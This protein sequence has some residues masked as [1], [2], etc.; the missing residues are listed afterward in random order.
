M[1]ALILAGGKGERLSALTK[2]LI[3]KPMAEICGKPILQRAVERLRENG[4]TELFMSVSHLR[5]VIENHFGDG[6]KFGVHIRYIVERQ[7]LGSGG[8]L[9]YLKDV[10]DD[11]FLVCPG[12]AIFDVDFSRMLAFHRE[13]NSLITMFAHPNSHPYDSD[14]IVSRDSGQVAEINYKNS[15]RNFYYKNTVSSG[16]LI[17][18]PKTLSFFDAP[19]TVNMEK[20]FVSHFVPQGVVYAYHSSEYVKDVGT[21]ER[22]ALAEKDLKSNLV[23][24]KNLARKQKAVFLDRDG[25]LN[26]YKGFIANVSDIELVDG[27]AEAIKKINRSEYLAIVVS[28]QAV[29]ARGEATF[30]DVNQMFAKIETLLGSGGAYLDGIFYCPHHPDK[31]YAGEVESLKTD[32]DCRKPKIGLL[33]QAEKK[34]NLDLSQ[35]VLIGDSNR[36]VE[37][38]LNAGIPVVK[39]K[40]DLTQVDKYPKCTKAENLTESVSIILGE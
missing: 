1:K 5:E 15:P 35:C 34:F 2:G 6:S 16:I 22:F 38:A 30:G 4:I 18:S 3:P 23:A 33:K 17:V 39:V 11:D 9:Y 25:T 13:K 32:C 20:D 29:I 7:P 10:M 28:N 24:K 19:K 12:D 27:A 21:P 36:D 14:L 31:G 37:T 26:K 40:S 8:A